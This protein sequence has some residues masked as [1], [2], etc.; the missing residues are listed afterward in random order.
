MNLKDMVIGETI[1]GKPTDLIES[2]YEHLGSL[3]KEEAEAVAHILRLQ[4]ELK[5]SYWEKSYDREEFSLATLP[6]AK[7]IKLA[8]DSG[9]LSASKRGTKLSKLLLSGHGAT[10]TTIRQIIKGLK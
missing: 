5:P 7:A 8:I 9:I 6:F 2:F 4:E 1:T 10:Y 3:N